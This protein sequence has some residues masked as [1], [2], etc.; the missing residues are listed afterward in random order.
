MRGNWTQ[1]LID[2]I[3][4]RQWGQVLELCSHSWRHSL[5]TKTLLQH[6]GTSGSVDAILQIMQVRMSRTVGLQLLA[7][8]LQV[9]TFPWM[10]RSISV[11]ESI[12]ETIAWI[13]CSV[14]MVWWRGGREQPVKGCRRVRLSGSPGLS[15]SDPEEICTYVVDF[16]RLALAVPLDRLNSS[17][18]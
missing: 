16:G 15:E 13:W 9:M 18:L 4:S 14:T 8:G 12:F 11:F 7:G 17:S 6:L 1:S 5:H 10:V 3:S 2:K